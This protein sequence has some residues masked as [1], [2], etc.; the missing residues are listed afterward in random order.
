MA[1]EKR[2]YDQRWNKIW[3]DGLN[4][5]EQFDASSSSPALLALIK[6]GKLQVRGKKVFVPGCGRGYDVVEFAKQGAVAVVGLELVP[7]AASSAQ[8]HLYSSDLDKTQRERSK[9]VTGDF[10]DASA[11]NSYDIGYDYT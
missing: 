10:F 8:E 3:E 5:G 1:H 2:D 7:E 6:E 11:P 4:A 9:V